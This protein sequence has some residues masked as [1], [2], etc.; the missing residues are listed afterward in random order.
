MTTAR[1]M[2]VAT[3]HEE[4]ATL[5][6]WS[7]TAAARHPEL[8]L[9]FAIPNGAALA[10]KSTGR[11]GRFSR[12]AMKLRAEGL[13]PG[14]PDLCLP[15]PR[16]KYH[17]LFIEMKRTKGGTLSAEQREWLASLTVQGYCAIRCN[18][19]LEARAAILQYLTTE[20]LIEG[21]PA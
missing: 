13:R 20:V 14:V 16:G 6:E 1:A 9:L 19:W 4:Q 5:V 15:V 11:R 12:Q 18:G 21:V 8:H 3:E 10:S 17:G 2:P 7:A